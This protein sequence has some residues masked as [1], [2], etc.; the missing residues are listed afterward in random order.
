MQ[1]ADLVRMSTQIAEFFAAYPDD[2][3]VP[4]VAEHLRSF[5]APSM[6]AQLIAM[7]EAGMPALHPLVQRAI[8]RLRDPEPAV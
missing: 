4:G 1:E 7:H 3:A 5:W 8:A 2:E 6:R